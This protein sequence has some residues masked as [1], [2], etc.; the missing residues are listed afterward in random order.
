VAT[1]KRKHGFETATDM[2]RSLAVVGAFVA[3]LVLVTLRSHPN[4]ITVINYSDQ[5]SVARAKATYSVLAPVGLPA[6]WRATSARSETVGRAV[7]WHLGFVTPADQYAALEQTDGDSGPFIADQTAKG[8][9]VGEVTVQGR[10]WQEFRSDSVKAPTALVRV[11]GQVTTVVAG[12]AK[13]A[14][15][16]TLTAALRGPAKP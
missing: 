6:G 2:I 1:T 16:E 5:L 7:H 14:E 10:P 8:A 15:L 9:P 12:T 11:D 13:L 4:P 3:V